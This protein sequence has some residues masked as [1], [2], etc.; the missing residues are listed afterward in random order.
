MTV[1]RILS[2]DVLVYMSQSSQVSHFRSEGL[3]IRYYCL[4]EKLGPAVTFF[5]AD[6]NIGNSIG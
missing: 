3:T 5:H 2:F 6:S 1:H 4:A